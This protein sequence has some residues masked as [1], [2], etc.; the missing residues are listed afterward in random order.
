MIIKHGV[1]LVP[2]GVQ[3][4]CAPKE[5]IEWRISF[6]VGEKLLMNTFRH[7]QLL[8]YAL[9]QVLMKDV[10]ASF[11]KCQD[12][13]C[14]YFL[15]TII[16]WVSEELPQSVWKPYNLIP[17]FMRCFSRLV[18]CVEH[19]VCQHYFI[20]E[21]NM[22]ENKIEGPVC[23]ILLEKLYT[24]RSYGWRCILFSDQVSNFRLSKFNSYIEPHTFHV[25]EVE[26]ILHSNSFTFANSFMCTLA[27]KGV[28]L[29]KRGIQQIVL[30]E[31]SSIK[32]FISYFMSMFCTSLAQTLPLNSTSSNNKYQYRQYKSCLTLM[33][34]NIYHDAVSG[35]LM[36]ASCF[37]KTKQYDNALHV[38]VYAISK[39]SPEKLY[40]PM[41][42]VDIHH[43][44]LKMKSLQKQN[45]AYLCKI[46]FVDF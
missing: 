28:F 10:K 39:C 7:T 2:I 30:S 8:C 24:L 45:I 18:Y 29:L 19:S 22:F 23:E 5:D 3:G 46:L 42:M 21:N 16:F 44:L 34:Q 33:L 1:L 6:S 11:S 40:R 35:W 20:P 41:A 27:M 17:C 13:L 43:Q 38:I 14:S 9:F 26:K 32:Y 37:Y 15:K 4:S 12:L 36:L 25:N 31:K